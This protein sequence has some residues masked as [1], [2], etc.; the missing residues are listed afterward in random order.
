MFML[1]T[2]AMN[3]HEF[4]PCHTKIPVA[5]DQCCDDIDNDKKCV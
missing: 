3:A 1:R 2:R 4:S 5:D